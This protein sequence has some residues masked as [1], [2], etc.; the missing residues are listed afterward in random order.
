MVRVDEVGVERGVVPANEVR[1]RDAESVGQVG[2]GGPVFADPSRPGG[3]QT[4]GRRTA[5]DDAA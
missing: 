4:R 3:G 5:L 1:L 2:R